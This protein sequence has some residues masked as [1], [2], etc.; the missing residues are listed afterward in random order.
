MRELLQ[1][2]INTLMKSHRTQWI[3]DT[4]TYLPWAERVQV[5]RFVDNIIFSK[6]RRMYEE[7]KI[8]R[9]GI[10]PICNE[11]RGRVNLIL[12]GSEENLELLF[13][14]MQDQ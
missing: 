9:H 7:G 14:A 3:E 12:L 11:L 8:P 4:Q 5:E 1:L 2:Q 6:L 13:T 10:V